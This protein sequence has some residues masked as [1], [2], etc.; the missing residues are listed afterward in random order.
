VLLAHDRPSGHEETFDA[1]IYI[2]DDRKSCGFPIRRRY[3]RLTGASGLQR[4]LDNDWRIVNNPLTQRC[5][6]TRAM[7]DGAN[8]G[9]R[10]LL[11]KG[12]LLS[13]VVVYGAL[14]LCTRTATRMLTFLS[15]GRLPMSGK[16]YR[17]ARHIAIGIR[18]LLALTATSEK[19]Q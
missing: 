11:L 1:V 18:S 3:L 16:S 4:I 8:M 5:S 6:Y 12:V 13:V 9:V 10:R 17:T 19:E 14:L 2:V 15:I 7:D